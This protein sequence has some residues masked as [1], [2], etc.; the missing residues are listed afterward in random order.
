M[1]VPSQG[2]RPGALE[3]QGG[4]SD[5][6]LVSYGASV[7]PRAPRREPHGALRGSSVKS[8]RGQIVT[9]HLPGHSFKDAPC[10]PHLAPGAVREP[11]DRCP[12][13]RPSPKL[14]DGD[15]LERHCHQQALP[16]SS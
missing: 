9:L 12:P 13:N 3:A 16:F 8:V 15:A 4:P 5:R 14:K 2:A 6:G 7:G 10:T 11:A 1:R